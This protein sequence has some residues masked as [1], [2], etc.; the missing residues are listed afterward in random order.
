MSSPNSQ[1]QLVKNFCFSFVT[2]IFY[3]L[4][5]K[6]SRFFLSLRCVSIHRCQI[7]LWWNVHKLARENK[8]LFIFKKERI[9]KI[10]E[11]QKEKKNWKNHLLINSTF[12][13][14]LIQS[15]AVYLNCKRGDGH[16]LTFIVASEICWH[17]FLT[18]YSCKRQVYSLSYKLTRFFN[19]Q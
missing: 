18:Y 8:V 19:N 5:E 13:F 16:F 17:S 1:Q 9:L 14:F 4:Q 15:L 12:A 3:I 10:W 6:M 7:S 2:E 11:K